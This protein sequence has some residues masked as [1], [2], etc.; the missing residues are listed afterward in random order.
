MLIDEDLVS[1]DRNGR[2]KAY[3]VP[4]TRL[5]EKLGKRIVANM[6][7]VGFFTAITN[8]LSEESVREAIRTSVPS[9]TDKLNLAAFEAGFE[10]GRTLL[11]MGDLE[12]V[13][14]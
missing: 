4:A 12:G 14:R 2:P 10:H 8:L 5:A 9:G 13:G 11:G 3:A 7:M 6:V 1:P